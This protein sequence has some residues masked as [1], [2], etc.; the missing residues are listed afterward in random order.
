MQDIYLIR[1]GESTMNVEK[2]F[3]GWNECDL[4]ELGKVQAK[5]MAEEIKKLDIKKIY[6]SPL[7]RAFMTAR[8]IS[9]NII[10]D[11]GLKELNFGD[12]DSMPFKE[13]EKKYSDSMCEISSGNFDYTYP[14]GENR[15][16]FFE[17]VTSTYDKII[18]NDN[19]PKII[20]VAHSCVIRAILS[21]LLVGNP[22]LY[23]R[24]NI[25]NAGISKISYFEENGE[26][27]SIIKYINREV[28][29]S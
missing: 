27:K 28:E 17:R 25:S 21:N 16:E 14:N 6:S 3:C 9:D 8:I 20:I 4:S 1:H 12:F 18:S 23:F 5:S 13:V 24:F 26:K 7:K 15:F 22:D 11:E 2:K 29:I 19:T 10:T